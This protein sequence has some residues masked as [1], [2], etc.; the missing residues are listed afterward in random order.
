MPWPERQRRA[1][2]LDTQ[3][4]KG[5]M[6]AKEMMDEAGYGNGEESPEPPNKLRCKRCGYPLKKTDKKCPKCG[7]PVA[8]YGKPKPEYKRDMAA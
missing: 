4:R 8:R 2:F 3:R 6:A 1:I 5:T 7:T